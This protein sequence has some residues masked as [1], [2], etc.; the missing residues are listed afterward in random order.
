MGRARLPKGLWMAALVPLLAAAVLPAQIQTL[1]CRFTGVVMP[2][3]RCCPQAQQAGQGAG[4]PGAL[5]PQQAQLRGETCCLVRTVDLPRLLS[6]SGRQPDSAS[7]R[8]DAVA[9][10]ARIAPVEPADSMPGGRR[11][12]AGGPPLFG[13]PIVLLKRAFLI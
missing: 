3:E 10:L 8:A 2:A 5:I 1:V 4:P 9:L 13:P 11:P 7:P 6:V 12:T